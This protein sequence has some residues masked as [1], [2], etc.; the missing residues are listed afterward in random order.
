MHN[1]A[2]R[3][4]Y[5]VLTKHLHARTKTQ[6]VGAA[7]WGARH[8]RVQSISRN[9]NRVAAEQGE[10][11][12]SWS[13]DLL[14]AA[15]RKTGSSHLL[16]NSQVQSTVVCPSVWPLPADFLDRRPLDYMVSNVLSYMHHQIQ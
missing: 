2:S 15:F 4:L 14:L 6:Q 8:N 12:L 1:K 10:M 13:K 7:G 16:V 5:A 9:T 11:K 3:K